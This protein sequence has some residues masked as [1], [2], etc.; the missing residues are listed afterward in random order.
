MKLDLR[1]TKAT[2]TVAETPATA[3]DELVLDEL[4]VPWQEKLGFDLTQAQWINLVIR[5]ILLLTGVVG[6]KIYEVK[7]IKQLNVDKSILSK[8]VSKLQGQKQKLEKQIEGFGTL[9]RQSKQFNAKLDIIQSIMND[10]IW[11]IKGLDQI[12]SSIPEKV[13]L[14]KIK[15][16]QKKFVID[17]ASTSN[18][19]IERFVESLENTQLFSQVH[20]N[21]MTERKQTARFGSVNRRFFTIQSILK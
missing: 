8:E 16:R 12:R 17:G 5:A 14:N 18:K 1:K 9:S 7:N 19:E 6:L 21:Q 2:T 11:A 20:L 10:R 15:Y 4:Q 13:W 3:D